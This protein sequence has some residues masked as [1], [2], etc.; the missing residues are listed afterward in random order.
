[1]PTTSPLKLLADQ[2]TAQQG[3]L[4]AAYEEIALARQRALQAC[5]VMHDACRQRIAFNPL[6]PPQVL[7]DVDKPY[8]AL[9]RAMSELKAVESKWTVG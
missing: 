2:T 5:H 1:M 8:T 4:N 3:K 6:A 9:G 7:P